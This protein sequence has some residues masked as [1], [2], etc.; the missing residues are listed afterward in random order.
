MNE[1]FETKLM[2]FYIKIFCKFI[3]NAVNFKFWIV[4]QPSLDISRA[5][6]DLQREIIFT[7][8]AVHTTVT[9]A[10]HLREETEHRRSV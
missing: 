3:A 7:P 6:L 1:I 8:T 10:N 5:I 4:N 9:L 2:K